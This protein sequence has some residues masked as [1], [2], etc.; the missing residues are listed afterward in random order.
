MITIK[1]FLEVVDYRIN[2][3][4]H[5]QWKCYGSDAYGFEIFQNQDSH[6]ATM[7]FD[8]K[9]QTVYQIEAHDL[10]N[11]RSY[12]WI[13]PDFRSAHSQ[14]VIDKLGS[15]DKD[16]A[17]D[18]VHFIDLEVENDILEKTRAIVHE[19]DYDARVKIPVEFSDEEL[20]KYMKM[21]HELDITFNQLIEN[22]LREAV[23]KYL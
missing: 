20:L 9:N 7:V 3:G 17:Y 6:S 5:Y 12:R 16:V 19:E 2:E 22:A 4:Y 18:D 15:K 23:K 10:K 8:L 11:H 21:A 14:E 1:D 13:H